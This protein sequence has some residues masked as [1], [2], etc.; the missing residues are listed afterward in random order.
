MRI[1]SNGIL[2]MGYNLD[3]KD[4]YR[5]NLTELRNIA[6]RI[7]HNTSNIDILIDKLN[8]LLNEVENRND[9]N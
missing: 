3:P 4:Q 8:N 7:K 5:E 6:L 9:D 2:I 1:T